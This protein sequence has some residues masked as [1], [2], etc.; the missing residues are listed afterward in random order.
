MVAVSSN[1]EFVCPSFRYFS[2]LVKA[3]VE[4]KCAAVGKIS[5]TAL[6]IVTVT[7]LNAATGI[8]SR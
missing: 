2:V 7:L 5:R 8:A 3:V 4:I 1:A 6:R